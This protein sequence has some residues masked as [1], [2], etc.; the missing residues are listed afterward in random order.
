MRKKNCSDRKIC[1]HCKVHTKFLN[2]MNQVYL[3][4]VHDEI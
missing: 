1:T 3:F 2:H 4:I